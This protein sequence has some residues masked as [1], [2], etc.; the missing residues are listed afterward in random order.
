MNIVLTGGTSGLGYRTAKV[1]GHEIKNKI[2][3]IG[4]NKQKGEFSVENLIKETSNNNMV[5]Y[6]CE[7]N[8]IFK[9][10]P[11]WVLLFASLSI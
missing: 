3:L 10:I 4:S 9:N 6:L 1:L 2:I 7:N 5:I 11:N 8:F